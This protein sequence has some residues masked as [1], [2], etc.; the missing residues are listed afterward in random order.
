MLFFFFWMTFVINKAGGMVDFVS[1]ML[2]IIAFI[3]GYFKA[4]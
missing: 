4:V 1:D 2:L 3:L